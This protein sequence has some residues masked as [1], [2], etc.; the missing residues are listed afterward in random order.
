MRSYL[1]PS[2]FTPAQMLAYATA[3]LTSGVI[4]GFIYLII[5]AH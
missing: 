3:C 5:H 1:P 2:I 4:I